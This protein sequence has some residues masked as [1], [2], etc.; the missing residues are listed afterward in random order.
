MSRPEFH[1]CVTMAGL[2]LRYVF[3]GIQT[4]ASRGI[5][6]FCSP[7][8]GPLF[9]S[10]VLHES[11]A[12]TSRGAERKI[13]SPP[14]GKLNLAQQKPE[15]TMAK[16]RILFSMRNDDSQTQPG[17]LDRTTHILGLEALVPQIVPC[18]YGS[19]SHPFY[20]SCQGQGDPVAFPR[21]LGCRCHQN[22][23]VTVDFQQVPYPLTH[24]PLLPSGPQE[25]TGCRILLRQ[26][27]ILLLYTGP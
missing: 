1:K 25:N 12:G 17:G 27:H 16:S 4:P 18:W 23:S 20:T 8:L 22:R 9:Q 6:V 13:R 11:P 2:P 10:D 19:L 14:G 15:E 5:S 21:E 7:G 3:P 24:S 26:T